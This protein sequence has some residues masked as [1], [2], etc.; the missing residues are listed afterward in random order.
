ELIGCEGDA[1]VEVEVATSRRNP[2]KA[3]PHAFLVCRQLRVRRERHRGHS[4]VSMIEVDRDSV[5]V[6]HPKRADKAGRIFRIGRVLA[7]GFR[8]EH[9]VVDH[10]LAA[11]LKEIGQC[12]TAILTFEEV[13]LVYEF[14]REFATLL[15][16]LITKAGELLFFRQVLLPSCKPFFMGHYCVSCHPTSYKHYPASTSNGLTNLMVRCA[17]PFTS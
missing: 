8:I 12:F 5:E 2:W 1:I 16:E 3:P 13:F 10:Q 4:D 15:A 7:S 6:V 9:G 17:D 11:A 14:P